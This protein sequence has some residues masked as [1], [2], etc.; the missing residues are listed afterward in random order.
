MCGGVQSA[1]KNQ[2]NVPV[3]VL[4]PVLKSLELCFVVLL[5]DLTCIIVLYSLV[6]SPPCLTKKKKKTVCVQVAGSLVYFST[7]V[8]SA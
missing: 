4:E 3:N 5:G 8:T 2:L 1:V 7:S 6:T